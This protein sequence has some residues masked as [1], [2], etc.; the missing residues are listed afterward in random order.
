MLGSKFCFVHFGPRTDF[1]QPREPGDQAGAV[2]DLMDHCNDQ[3]SATNG[4]VDIIKKYRAPCVYPACLEKRTATSNLCNRHEIRSQMSGGKGY[5]CCTSPGCTNPGVPYCIGHTRIFQFEINIDG[6]ELVAAAADPRSP[7]S[8]PELKPTD[9][10]V[11][12]MAAMTLA[13]PTVRQRLERLLAEQG[14]DIPELNA[15]WIEL[16]EKLIADAASGMSVD[17]IFKMA[18][19]ALDK[20]ATA[21]L[22]PMD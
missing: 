2:L 15:E 9:P 3:L 13:E 22:A 20:R 14:Y 21:A 6:P 1:T 5:G 7:P 17:T 11:T 4:I 19:L 18:R 8:S 12:A 16:M 10:P